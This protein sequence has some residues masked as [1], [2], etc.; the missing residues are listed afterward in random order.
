ME[1]LKDIYVL[2]EN[3]NNVKKQIHVYDFKPRFLEAILS[4]SST[5]WN[6]TIEK[7]SASL[8]NERA[9]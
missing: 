1:Y 6:L 4:N 9:S 3:V 7:K 8:L 5:K 2:Y